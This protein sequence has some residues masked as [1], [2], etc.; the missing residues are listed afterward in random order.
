MIKT[1]LFVVLVLS[2]NPDVTCSKETA[3]ALTTALPLASHCLHRAPPFFCLCVSEIRIS[4]P[5]ER[6]IWSSYRL[7][8]VC[9]HMVLTSLTQML[10]SDSPEVWTFP[11]SESPFHPFVY[12]NQEHLELC[13]AP[14]SN[15]CLHV[16]DRGEEEE[17]GSCTAGSSTPAVEQ[18]RKRKG[19]VEERSDAQ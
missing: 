10:D 2:E 4:R 11:Q 8:R 7:S 17:E 9:C 3:V 19:A 15:G 6:N 14:P 18:P 12:I 13:L 16:S 1:N 5:C